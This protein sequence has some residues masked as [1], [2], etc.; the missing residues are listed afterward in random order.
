MTGNYMDCKIQARLARAGARKLQALSSERRSALLHRVAEDIRKERPRILDIN[1]EDVAAGKAAVAAGRLS[2]ALAARLALN[3]RKIE[4]LVDGIHA[5]ADMAEPI[6]RLLKRTELARGLELRQVTAP[7]GVLLVIF[8][9]RP[10][11]LPQVA[12]LALR[13]GNGL[14][15]KGGTEAIR[16]NRLLHKIITDSIGSLV[17]AGTIGLVETREEIAEL[18]EMDELVDLV[19]PRG[20]SEL[21][22]HIQANTKI[23]VLGHAEGVC[24]VYLD[25][26]ADLDKAVDVILDAKTDYPAACNAMETLLLHQ[27]TVEDGRAQHIVESLQQAGVQLYGDPVA[28][29]TLSLPVAECLNREHSDLIATVAVVEDTHAAID[30]IH[31]HGS[32]HT[33]VILTEDSEAAELFLNSVD[34]ACV[35]HNASTRFADGFRFGLGAEVGISTSPIHARGPVGV[36]GLLTTRWQLRGCGDVVSDFS[37]GDR[38]F[39]HRVLPTG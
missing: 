39:T 12:A 8:E 14:L 31:T 13:S 7:I 29:R 38:E 22:R 24:H 11:A 34:S 25:D 2:E 21:V 33:E 35:F 16:S 36:E 3:V 18:L 1:A 19:I 37:S 23:P 4:A 26:A 17:P 28:H 9:A 6:G 10:D 32:G 20:S 27:A 15:L 30:H 5:I